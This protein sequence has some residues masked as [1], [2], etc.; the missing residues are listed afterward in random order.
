MCYIVDTDTQLR[1]QIAAPPRHKVVTPCLFVAQPMCGAY[2]P[3]FRDIRYLQL[4][5][6][7]D[8]TPTRDTSE[9]KKLRFK[10]H[11]HPQNCESCSPP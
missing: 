4:F 2:S 10:M 8:D 9:S 7:D 3:F 6:D 1:W 5:D 11:M